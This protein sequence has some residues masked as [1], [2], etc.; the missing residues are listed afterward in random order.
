M[1]RRGVRLGLLN[2]VGYDTHPNV[3]PGAGVFLNWFDE[4]RALS[5]TSAL[6]G[7]TDA[8]LVHLHWGDE[9]LRMPA[10]DQRRIARKLVDAGAKVVVGCHAHVLQG[11]EPWSGGYIFHGMGNLL[12]WPPPQTP[13]EHSGPWP[14]YVREVGIACCRL[15]GGKVREVTVRHLVQ[16]GLALRWDE[17]Q[18][19]SDGAQAVSL[20]PPGRSS[21]AWARRV[22]A[23][24]TRHVLFRLHSMRQAGGFWSWLA[25]RLRRKTSAARPDLHR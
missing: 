6:C 13:L 8:V 18:N 12:F 9:F 15:A 23:F 3:P 22:E 16:D 11:H 20:A 21:F 7:K 4:E 19:A 1:Q 10:L 14:R 5:E 24:H 25:A 17:T 2:Y